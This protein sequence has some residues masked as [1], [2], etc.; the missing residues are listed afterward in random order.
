[1]AFSTLSIGTSALLTAKY[2]LEVTGQNLGN[3]DTPGYARQRLNQAA[4]RG[5]IAVNANSII[6][7]GVGTVSVKRIANEF[8]EKQLRQAYSSDTY[9]GNLQNCY[10]NIQAYF[11]ESMDG[12]TGLSSAMNGFWNS[13]SDFATQVENVAVRKTA[14]EEAQGMVG[15]FNSL[16]SQLSSYRS[17]IDEQIVESVSQI[18]ELLD[19]IAQL[20]RAIVNSELGGATNYSAN[21]LR[22]QR[23]EAAKELAKYMDIDVMEEAN[24]SFLV[25]IHGRN[26]VF[27][28]QAKHIDIEKTAT[29]DGRMVNT[30]VFGGDRYPLRPAN[31]ELAAQIEMRDVII[32][33]YKDNIDA[34]AA[35]FI[36]EFNR[37]HSQA[38]GLQTYDSLTSLNAPLNPADTLDKL[39][40]ND[41]IPAGT[42]QIVNGNFEIIIQDRT[43]SD[44]TASPITVNIEVD[45]DGRPSPDGEP[46]MILWD[47]DNP[48]ATNSLVNRMQKALDEAL[49]G[50]F[51]VTIDREYRVT[52]KSKSDDYGF[53][54]GEDSSGVL[55]ALGMNV[56]FT[57]HNAGNMG[58]NQQIRDNPSLL[59]GAFSFLGGDSE[60]AA[61]LI[62]VRDK[63]LG[64]LAS[65]T[66]GDY[67][68][69]VT[70]RLGS[71]ASRTN[72]QKTLSQDLYV[73]MFNQRESMSGVSEDEEVTRLITYQRAYQSAAKFISI[74]DQL[75]ETLINM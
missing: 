38:L 71:E 17:A 5:A 53:G 25:S 70:G 6:G 16:S 30:P 74:V 15:M 46:D 37:A 69:S 59:G 55:A 54:F 43:N 7:N 62:A 2:G 48:G 45:L 72:S 1:M 26:L 73:N 65:M 63:T 28:D 13:L 4:N 51:E 23:G 31:G 44:P 12:S 22:D 3:I 18:N 64:A 29:A 61:S 67:Y 57:G 40:Y 68:L 35:N 56:F 39:R 11:N 33:G 20:N 41:L 47:P 34:L 60:G 36:W 19:E 9:Y 24:G 8:L 21:D 52:I 14:I 10:S 27:F 75:Y 32:Q 58:I 50:V 49:P 66:L 42:F